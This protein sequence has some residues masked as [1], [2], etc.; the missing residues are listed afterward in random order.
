[1][2][3]NVVNLRNKAGHTRPVNHQEPQFDGEA[4]PTAEVLANPVALALW[5]DKAPELI[6]KGILT[7]QDQT[8]FAAYCLQHSLR[9]SYWKL[10]LEVGE[11]LAIAKGYFKA[12][13]TADAACMRWGAKF[14][15][16]PSDRSAIK[17]IPKEKPQGARRFL[18]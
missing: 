14:G 1:L 5:T 17:A 4:V 15:L 16:N 3:T 11:E 9:M 2:P 13:Q 18:A 6:E 7:N 8:A 10:M 12:Y